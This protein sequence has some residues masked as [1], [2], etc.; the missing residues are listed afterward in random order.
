MMTGMFEYAPTEPI[1][2]SS[3]AAGVISLRLFVTSQ[4]RPTPLGEIAA[5]TVQFQFV[6]DRGFI[7]ETETFSF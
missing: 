5:Y 7:A 6:T 3:G 1:V 4:N 2:L